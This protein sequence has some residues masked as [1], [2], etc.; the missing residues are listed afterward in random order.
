MLALPAPW[1]HTLVATGVVRHQSSES[2]WLRRGGKESLEREDEEVQE[3]TVL[4]Y[5]RL[6]AQLEEL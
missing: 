3:G 1:C 5:L 2:H 6:A 4:L